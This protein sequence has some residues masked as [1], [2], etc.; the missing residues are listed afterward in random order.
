[1]VYMNRGVGVF[2]A[3][4]GSGLDTHSASDNSTCQGSSSNVHNSSRSEDSTDTSTLQ[5][6]LEA[7]RYPRL[8]ILQTPTL[9]QREKD[10]QAYV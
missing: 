2:G 10:R 7:E 1:M 4:R 9:Q 5:A 3:G 8:Q 6:P